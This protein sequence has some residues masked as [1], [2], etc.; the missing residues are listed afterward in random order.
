MIFFVAPAQETWCMEAYLDQY[1]GKLL[2]RIKILTFED[3]AA[4][5]GLSP[6]TYILS[7]IDQLSP[8][9][10]EIAELC[11][12]ELS[13]ASSEITLVNQPAEVLCRY[14]LLKTCFELKRNT[15]HVARASNFY[16][17]QNF[18]VFIRPE[19]EHTGSLT[20]L[21]YTPQQLALALAKT[22]RH[23]YRLRDLIIV[24][25]RE[26]VDSSG[27]FRE[28]CASIVGDRIIPQ[29]LV[30]NYNWVTKWE[31][32]LID[33]EKAREEREY[34]ESNPH[35][36]WLRKTFELA[37]IQYG[38]IDYGFRCGS[39]QVWEINT[40]PMI[41][42]PSGWPPS[43]TMTAEQR[44]LRAPMRDR[45]LREFHAALEA[46]DSTVDPNRTIRIDVSRRQQR[47][48]EAEKRL[49]LRL[50][51]RKT[52]ISFAY[53]LVYPLIRPLRRLLPR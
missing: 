15:F 46:I 8:T 42:R 20:S 40:N 44:N 1:G 45:F 29:A 48:L 34:V 49:R 22:L 17:C 43:S 32:R 6:G 16:R 10:R 53:E 31:G 13:R 51:A 2:T 38:R 41:V 9:E 12:K 30:H 36:D 26:T 27:I 19:H 7:A 5:Q 14:D 3:I 4:Q 52:A 28:Y 18:P 24:E 37:K 39:P 25:Y 33:A 11:W 50:R 21:L 47:K 35:A 23:G